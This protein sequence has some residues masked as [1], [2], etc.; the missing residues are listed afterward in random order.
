MVPRAE[1]AMVIMHQGKALGP[2]VVPEALYAG[3]V[4][5]VAATCVLAPMVLRP[6]LQRRGEADSASG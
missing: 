6:L 1:I 2:E 3:M 4:L 5:T